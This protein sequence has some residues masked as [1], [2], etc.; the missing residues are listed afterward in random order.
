[1]LLVRCGGHTGVVHTLQVPR[2]VPLICCRCHVPPSLLL[3]SPHPSFTLLSPRTEAELVLMFEAR[4]GALL[5]PRM[6]AE[7]PPLMF[8]AREG[9]SLSFSPRM[10][11][12]D[13][14]LHL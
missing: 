1:V 7:A 4:E 9:V 5:S 14:P 13:P 10:E 6:E 11:V 8:E 2:T 3:W 12:E